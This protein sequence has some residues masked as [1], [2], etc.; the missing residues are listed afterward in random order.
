M[1]ECIEYGV[2]P[3]T[4]CIEYGFNMVS[5]K[6]SFYI[7]KNLIVVDE[8]D[9]AWVRVDTKVSE[10]RGGNFL[11]SKFLIKNALSKLLGHYAWWFSLWDYFYKLW[12]K[13]PYSI[14]CCLLDD[15]IFNTLF[16][17]GDTP[18]M[19]TMSKVL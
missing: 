7:L 13:M 8:T 16:Y 9:A 11:Q 4:H 15:T 3:Y 2:T 14:Q 5:Y 12:C 10:V 17:L 18:V 1:Q 6:H 19:N